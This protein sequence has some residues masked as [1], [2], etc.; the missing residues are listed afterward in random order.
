MKTVENKFEKKLGC[1]QST[2]LSY[3]DR[4]VLTN[5]ILSILPIFMISFLEIPKESGKD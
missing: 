3:E 2:L 4:V 5:S 1:W